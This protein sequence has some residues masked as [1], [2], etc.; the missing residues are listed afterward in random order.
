MDVVIKEQNMKNIAV[1]DVFLPEEQIVIQTLKPIGKGYSVIQSACGKLNISYFVCS[2][3]GV[4]R[5][6]GDFLDG[7]I[8]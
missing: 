2:V 1:E 5:N 7:W 6:G 3:A 4:Y 8:P